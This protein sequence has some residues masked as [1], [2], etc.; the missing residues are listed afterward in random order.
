MSN[1]KWSGV[2][3]PPFRHAKV[4]TIFSLVLPSPRDTYKYILTQP[5]D[6]TPIDLQE[7]LNRVVAQASARIFVGLPL[8]RNEDWLD[9]SLKFAT[10]VMVGGEK[11]KQWHPWL[12]PIAQF[13]VPEV[14]R[15]KADHNHAHDLLLPELARRNSTNTDTDKR[16]YY[17]TIEWM[18]KRAK[19]IG[20]T[21]FD[22]K[23]LAKIQMLTATAAI[24]TTRLAITHALLDLAARPEYL[25]PLREEIREVTRDCGGG[26]L[27]KQHLTHL[28]KLDSFMKESMR[29]SP[30]SVG[31]LS[32]LIAHL[33]IYRRSDLTRHQQRFSE[34]P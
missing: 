27:Q 21:S 2:S 16:P 19:N 31:R 11:L 8:C 24:H 34:K 30:A 22:S 29:H 17:D 28:K 1:E 4:W 13:F 26:L 18:Q 7:N 6:W 33:P 25:E 23:E 15:I 9:S 20:D 3:T 10:D 5:T 32:L 14:N 12:R